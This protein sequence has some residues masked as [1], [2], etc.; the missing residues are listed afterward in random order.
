MNA[1]A[2]DRM[3]LSYSEVRRADP[4]FEVAI[5][6]ALGDAESVLNV[7]AG[8]GSYEPTDREIIAVEPSSVMIVQRPA[9]AAPAIRGVAESLPLTDKSVDATMGVFTMQH[10]DDVDRGL[11]EVLRVTRERIVLLTL[12]LDVTAEMWLCSDYLPEIIEHDRKTFPSIAHLKDVLPGLQVEVV[13]VPAD[14][15]DGFC[16][17]LWSRPEMHLDPDVRRASSIWHLLPP[18][19]L[20]TGLDRLRQ[21]LESGEWDRRHGQLRTQAALDVGLRLVTAELR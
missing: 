20:D 17:A 8:A 6:R 18:S 14:C 13:P 11:A 15:T 7:G 5:W 1:P 9:D 10:W 21:D 2:Y 19:V 3:G 16:V 4:R 12:D